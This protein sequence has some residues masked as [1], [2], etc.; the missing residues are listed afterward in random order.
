M[1]SAVA[2][3]ETPPLQRGDV[4][5]LN[6]L[7]WGRLGEAMATHSGRDVFVFGGIP[8]EVGKRRGCGHPTQIRRRPGNQTCICSSPHRVEPPCGHISDECTGCQWQ[9]VSYPTNSLTPKPPSWWT[10]W[11]ESAD[12]TCR[13]VLDTLFHPPS[14]SATATMPGS[15]CGAPRAAWDS[16]TANA[17][18]LSKLTAAC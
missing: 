3:T 12:S 7:S 5:E 9:H 8:G 13:P 10:R 6:L 4:I 11:S 14:R 15:T 17:G 16:P 18:G 1:T 2:T